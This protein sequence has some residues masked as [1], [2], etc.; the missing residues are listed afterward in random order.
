V[1]VFGTTE[2][3]TDI[4]EYLQNLVISTLGT[5]PVTPK[6]LTF[7]GI[8]DYK[9]RLL[10]WFKGQ[11]IK[12]FDPM[13]AVMSKCQ[14]LLDVLASYENSENFRGIVFVQT[15]ESAQKLYNFL[16]EYNTHAKFFVRP[17]VVTGNSFIRNIN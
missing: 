4:P 9:P 5:L 10:Q 7:T 12:K 8:N 11:S 13:H 2:E 16:S 15:R 6:H 3:P 17:A 1:E 14:K